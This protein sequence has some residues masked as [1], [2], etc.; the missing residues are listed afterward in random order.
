MTFRL[1]DLKVDA[2]LIDRFGPGG[3][4]IDG[5]EMGGSFVDGFGIDDLG[6]DDL[7]LKGLSRLSGLSGW[8]V[9]RLAWAK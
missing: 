5:R 9:R 3:P 8:P 1:G 2:P 6:M 4:E 7:G